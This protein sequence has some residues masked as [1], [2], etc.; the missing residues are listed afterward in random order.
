M[1]VMGNWGV[2]FPLVRPGSQDF[3]IKLMEGVEDIP[4]TA[5]AEGIKWEWESFPEYLDA[6]ERIP[7]ALDIGAQVPH[8]ALRFYVM[9]E[10]G[11]DHQQH[12]T[13]DEIDTMGR[14]V[15]DAV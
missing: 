15:R 14:L 7:H 13:A 6:V 3:L 4:G 5:L 12:P 9:G 8:A 10:R 1:A 11:A 2:G